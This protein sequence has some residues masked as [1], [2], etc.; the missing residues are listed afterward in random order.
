MPDSFLDFADGRDYARVREVFRV[1]GYTDEAVV[2]AL[3]TEGLTA[4]GAKRVP[5]LLRRTAGGT[6]LE[7]LIRL[8]IL[9]VTVDEAAAQGALA[10]MTVEEWLGL[11]LLER[12]AGGVRASLQVRCYEDLLV[13]WDFSLGA[14]GVLARDYV[15][16]I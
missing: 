1:A 15:M 12:D 11:G 10:P 13:A 7:T 6:P 9:G 2:E 3:R 16:G 4:V 14:R 8:F 5:P